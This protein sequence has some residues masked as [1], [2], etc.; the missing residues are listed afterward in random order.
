MKG[1]EKIKAVV[2]MLKLVIQASIPLFAKLHTSVNLDRW[3]A[4][5]LTAFFPSDGFLHDAV[6]LFSPPE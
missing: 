5:S 6:T 3:K 2:I 1:N 4:T